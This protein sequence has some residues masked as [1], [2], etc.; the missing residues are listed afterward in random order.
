MAKQNGF[1]ISIKAF[2]PAGKTTEE[3]F[4]VLSAIKDAKTSG[5]F[6]AV[7]AGAVDVEVKTEGKNRLI[8]APAV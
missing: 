2:I 5:K 4:A 3:Q 6:D 8:A 7:M 1:E